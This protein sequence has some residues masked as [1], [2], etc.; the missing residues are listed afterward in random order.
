LPFLAIDL[1]SQSENRDFISLN[2]GGSDFHLKDEHASPLIFSN[3]GFAPSIQYYHK[4]DNNIHYFEAS[5]YRNYLSSTVPDFN[6]DN[7][8]VKLR[9]SYLQNI[10]DLRLFKH[11]TKFFVGGSAS[12]FFSKS[13]Y[14]YFDKYYNMNFT[15]IWTWYWS[16][17]LDLDMR[18]EYKVNDGKSLV[19]DFDLP[20]ISNVSRPKY[21]PIGDYSYA[22]NDWKIKT[23]GKTEFFWN[24][25]VPNLSVFYLMAITDHIDLQLSYEFFY[26]RYDEPVPVRQYMNNIRFGLV[27]GF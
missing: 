11:E 10:S 2:I 19:I 8:S 12:T 25:F 15:S 4:G 22:D 24:N 20:V 21:S 5:Y 3:T 13:N 14:Y 18:M 1:Y 23:F 27:Y 7:W 17:S 16:H 26:A 9:Y 6:T